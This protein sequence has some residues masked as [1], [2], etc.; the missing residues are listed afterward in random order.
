MSLPRSLGCDLVDVQSFPAGCFMQNPWCAVGCSPRVC[1]ISSFPTQLRPEKY[2]LGNVDFWVILV[3][4]MKC[5]DTKR[6][7]AT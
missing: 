7:I 3:S 5:L 1:W 2:Q 4:S 6:R